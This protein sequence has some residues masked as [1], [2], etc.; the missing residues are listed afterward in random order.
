MYVVVDNNISYKNRR[1]FA[2]YLHIKFHMLVYIDSLVV[3][4]K[5]IAK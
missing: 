4:T 5:W 3:A 2:I 1:I